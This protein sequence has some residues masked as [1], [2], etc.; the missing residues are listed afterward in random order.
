MSDLFNAHDLLHIGFYALGMI[1]SIAVVKTDIRW[2]R[3]WCDDHQ[4]KDDANFKDARDDIRELRKQVMR[5]EG[6]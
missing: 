2:I 3:K 5:G 4:Q 6:R 1:V